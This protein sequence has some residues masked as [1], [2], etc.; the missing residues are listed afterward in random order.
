VTTAPVGSFP[1]NGFGLY[2]MAG[3]A[4]EW[5]ADWYR[6]DSYASASSKNPAGPDSSFDP[7][8]PGVPKRVQRGGSFLCSD[9]YC[10]RYEVG[11]RGKGAPDSAANHIGFRC[12]RTGTGERPASGSQGAVSARSR[13]QPASSL[14]GS[15][16]IR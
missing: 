7:L 4:W 2:D 9:R 13:M 16:C 15:C 8:E 12:V 1:P 3:N 10:V 5:C 6:P 11:A 14:L